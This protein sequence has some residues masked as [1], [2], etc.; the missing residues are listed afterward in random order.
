[1]TLAFVSRG[2]N[3]RTTLCT[4]AERLRGFSRR[5]IA[6]FWRGL[7]PKACNPLFHRL[8]GLWYASH[9][10]RPTLTSDVLQ[11][12]AITSIEQRIRG[13]HS[14][15][16]RSFRIRH[17]RHE[18]LNCFACMSSSEFLYLGNHFRSSARV[19]ALAL[20]KWLSNRHVDSLLF[21]GYA[22]RQSSP[23]RDPCLGASSLTRPGCM[24]SAP[25]SPQF[26]ATHDRL[27]GSL[28]PGRAPSGVSSFSPPQNE[29]D[30]L[31]LKKCPDRFSHR[32]RS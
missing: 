4:A 9:V 18:R 28:A 13:C 16:R 3:S 22:V 24:L 5:T 14:R 19:A 11:R 2:V 12:L 21:C 26:H 25:G 27:Y 31:S 17:D 32:G 20:L 29:C 8:T 23:R 15:R 6:R 7:I 10:H 30:S 1:M